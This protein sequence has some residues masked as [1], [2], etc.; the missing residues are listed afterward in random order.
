M[1]LLT[2]ALLITFYSAQQLW[3]SYTAITTTE[4]LLFICNISSS[5]LVAFAAGY[6]LKLTRALNHPSI[7]DEDAFFTRLN[8]GI[9][10]FRTQL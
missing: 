5:L 6:N 4:L 2:I 8:E 3:G 7:N 1:I 10:V 9:I